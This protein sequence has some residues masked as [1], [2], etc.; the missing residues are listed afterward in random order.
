MSLIHDALKK[1]RREAAAQDDPGVVYPG[2]LTGRRDRAGLGA[3]LMIGASLALLAGIV[4]VALGWWIFRDG[5]SDASGASTPPIQPIP[6]VRAPGTD[7]SASND[8]A[9]ESEQAALT[10][11]G[12]TEN[13]VAAESPDP[14]SSPQSRAAQE[15][16]RLP[17]GEPILPSAPPT[18]PE[19]STSGERVFEVE[20]DL[21][22]AYLT[23]DYIVYRAND[24]YAQINSFDVRVGSHIDGFTVE[25]ITDRWVRL[26]DGR[27]PLVLKVPDSPADDAPEPAPDLADP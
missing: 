10:Q 11:G 2:G 22:Y 12:T 16:A 25:E 7:P 6:T 9:G 23:L 19:D 4:V 13:P 18:P 17:R 8:V 3:G 21:G 1:A 20:A 24:P 14:P 26:R 27:G 15:P 5:A